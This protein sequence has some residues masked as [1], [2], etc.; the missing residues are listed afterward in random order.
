[1]TT[2]KGTKIRIEFTIPETNY[3]PGRKA[4]IKEQI[5][6]VRAMAPLLFAGWKY[7]E[8]KE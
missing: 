5:E 6:Q 8:L 3:L 7:T 1:M 4:F 2:R